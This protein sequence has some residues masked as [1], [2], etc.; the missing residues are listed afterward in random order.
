[1][2]IQHFFRKTLTFF[3]LNYFILYLDFVYPR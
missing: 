3:A 1:M 2:I